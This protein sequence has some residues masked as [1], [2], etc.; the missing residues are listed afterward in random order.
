[1]SSGQTLPDPAL[2]ALWLIS[3]AR[4]DARLEYAIARLPRG[5]G[6]VFRHYHLDPRARRARFEELRRLARS[7]GIVVALADSPATAR[8][9]RADAVYG[10]PGRMTGAQQLLRLVTAH[11]FREIGAARRAGANGIVLSP[12]FPTRSHP[13]A[14]TLGPVR[15]RLLVRHA[16]VPVILLGGMTPR[17]ARHIAAHGW[18]AIDGLT[19]IAA[20][21]TD[22]V[23]T[24]RASGFD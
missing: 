19:M 10:P 15:A 1:M 11:S 16:G 22:G 24:H 6:L 14:P 7:R 5:S 13:G 9:W 8:R 2:P 4:N 20:G 21:E 18:A 17:R 23:D 3:D 12:V